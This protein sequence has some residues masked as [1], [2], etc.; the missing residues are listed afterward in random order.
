MLK[1]SLF[2][3]YRD[4]CSFLKTRIA[5]R[6]SSS[7]SLHNNAVLRVHGPDRK[8]IVASVSQVLD[9][10]GCAITKSEQW[11][12]MRH[13]LFFQRVEFQATSNS[14]TTSSTGGG[15]T[16]HQQAILDG[17]HQ[18]CGT[19]LQFDVNWRTRRRRV[20]IFVSTTAHC[21]WEL[22]LR[23]E[24]QELDCDIVAVVSNHEKLRHVAETFHIPF[25][26]FPTTSVETKETAE[27]AQL[28]MLQ[29]LK[30]DLIVLARYMQVLSPQFLQN[31]P[32]DH[33]LNIHHSFLPAFAGT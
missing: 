31:F 28:Q 27:K 22:L 8:G 23:H 13:Q 6:W 33:I 1:K 18:V 10:T 19:T 4:F 21:L 11:T 16:D 32:Y 17:L 3:D 15:I 29:E 14:N 9:Q 24:A 25:Y 12:D 20:A 5:S 2:T 30:V 7:S 26:V